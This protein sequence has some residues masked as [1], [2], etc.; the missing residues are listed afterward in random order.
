MIKSFS[1][2][3][4]LLIALLSMFFFMGSATNAKTVD[5]PIIMYHSLAGNYGDTSIDAT[6]FESDLQFLQE[7]G[8][9]SVTLSQ[10]IDFVH[11]GIPLPEKP[12]VLS[13][14][15]GYYNN[16]ALGL[17]LAEKYNMP[18]VVSVI[19]KDTERWSQ[20]PSPDLPHGHLS[21]TEIREMVNSGFV[22]I[23][24]H[25]WNLHKHENGR[26]G[27]LICKRENTE[28][29]HA[30]LQEDLGRLQLA[31]SIY[32]DIIPTSFVY[33]FGAI[34]PVANEILAELGFLATLSCYEGVNKLT[35][36][37]TSCLYDLCRYNRTSKR[38]VADILN[39]ISL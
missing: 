39:S 35:Q 25:T 30:L 17:P 10:L 3:L 36:G 8:F 5:V 28:E 26:K 7:Q 9:Q 12:I 29:Y 31:L 2:R 32:C 21:W 20:N 23:A 27:V 19:G 16:Y 11:R 18:I 37:D 24:N 33:P 6:A 14:D 38:S 1:R 34:C 15:D 22:E 4:F 13:F